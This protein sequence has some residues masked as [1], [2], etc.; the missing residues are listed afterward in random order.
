[1]NSQAV[2]DVR[3]C[4]VILQKL[5][6]SGVPLLSNAATRF[7]RRSSQTVAVLLQRAWL[8]RRIKLKA[9]HFVWARSTGAFRSEVPDERTFGGVFPQLLTVCL[10]IFRCDQLSLSEGEAWT[11]AT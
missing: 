8:F 2:P 4:V 3:S 5:D 7:T 10:V 1:M 9:A 11:A 6:A